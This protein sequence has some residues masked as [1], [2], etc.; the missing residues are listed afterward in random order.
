MCTSMHV[1]VRISD[2][3][4]LELQMIVSCWELNPG[5]LERQPVVLLTTE[6]SP[7]AHNL[8]ILTNQPEALVSSLAWYS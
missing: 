1:R 4:E 6:P 7:P 8:L 2:P 5:P 3:L